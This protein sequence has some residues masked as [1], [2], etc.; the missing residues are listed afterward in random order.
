VIVQNEARTQWPGGLAPGLYRMIRFQTLRQ[1]C[2][3]QG[4]TAQEGLTVIGSPITDTFATGEPVTA[5][6]RDQATVKPAGQ[7]TA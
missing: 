3:A 6:G 4:P 2:I 5:G 1:S 7:G